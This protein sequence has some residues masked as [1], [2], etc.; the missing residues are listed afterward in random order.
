MYKMSNDKFYKDS[1][2]LRKMID[3]MTFEQQES[4]LSDLLHE[5]TP[6]FYFDKDRELYHEKLNRIYST[7][8]EEEY[9]EIT[10]EMEIDAE[11]T[12]LLDNPRL[13]FYV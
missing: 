11:I 4:Y 8:P 9:P 5:Y 12:V 3:D 1:I 2:L 13:L 10:N 6:I 7:Y